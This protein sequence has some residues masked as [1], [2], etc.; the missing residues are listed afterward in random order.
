M[1]KLHFTYVT[2]FGSLFLINCVI[3][4][5]IE[6]TAYLIFYNMIQWLRSN[7]SAYVFGSNCNY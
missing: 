2:N 1:D 3:Y 6:H 4:N 5:S 7:H